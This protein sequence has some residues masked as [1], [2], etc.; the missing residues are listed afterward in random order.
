MPFLPSFPQPSF[1]GLPTIY[2]LVSYLIGQWCS[3]HS[4]QMLSPFLSICFNHH[5]HY[6]CPINFLFPSFR[7][8]QALSTLYFVTK[9]SFLMPVFYFLYNKEV[10]IILQNLTFISFYTHVLFYFVLYCVDQNY[11]QNFNPLPQLFFFQF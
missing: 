7:Y 11:Q 8:D 3:S 10:A 5:S 4:F 1:L 2:S 6:R 9:I